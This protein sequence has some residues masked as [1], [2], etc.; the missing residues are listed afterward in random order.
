MGR[1]QTS[2]A[3][4]RSK[5]CTTNDAS[6]STAWSCGI[7][8]MRQVPETDKGVIFVTSADEIG[9]VNLIV[10]RHIR[11][12]QRLALLRSRLLAVA[13]RQRAKDGGTYLIARRL[14]DVRHGWAAWSSAVR[15][16]LTEGL[17]RRQVARRGTLVTRGCAVRA[18]DCFKAINSGERVSLMGRGMPV[19]PMDSPPWSGRT[20]DAAFAVNHARAV[21]GDSAVW[22]SNF[23]FQ[24]TGRAEAA[25][26]KQLH[27]RRQ[28]ESLCPL[29]KSLVECRETGS[30][31][32]ARKVERICE[33]ETLVE[34]ID[35]H[36]NRVTIFERDVL[37]ARQRT[38]HAGNIPRW[39]FVEPAHDPLQFK[40][41]GHRDIRSFGERCDGCGPLSG[42]LYIVG[43]IDEEPR[44]DVC[45]KGPHE[46]PRR[47]R[48]SSDAGSKSS[49]RRGTPRAGALTMP[50]MS[51][52]SAVATERT[53][54]SFSP[55]DSSSTSILAP[56]PIP[57]RRLIS[58]GNTIWPFEETRSVD[59]LVF[60]LS[61][62]P[63]L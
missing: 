48:V 7:V 25:S 17:G 32:T 23:C 31:R 1:G 27:R 44:Q 61:N 22:P 38:Q 3:Q 57:S 43:I 6:G 34:R 50:A 62:G 63:P 14:M 33:I 36:Q 24:P 42:S 59:M 12:R 15:G 18:S 10:W 53:T 21:S 56:A 55:S 16:T 5:W 51:D 29:R 2:R 19:G 54:R 47:D 30:T 46:L 26:A 40:Q 28:R 8:T 20:V 35:R 13:R 52:M 4:S 58:A 39:Q 41:H 37:N 60:R 9:S 49:R 11:K 45:V